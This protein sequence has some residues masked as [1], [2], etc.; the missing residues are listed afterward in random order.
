MKKV[1]S[2][3]KLYV[4]LITVFLYFY[5]RKLG[6]SEKLL[7]LVSDSVDKTVNLIQDKHGVNKPFDI[8]SYIY[9]MIYNVIASSVFGKRYFLFDYII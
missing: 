1:L 4:I 8:V 3:S 5:F 9:L 7:Y 6:S 2:Y